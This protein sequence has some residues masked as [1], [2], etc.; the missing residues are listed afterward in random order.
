[1]GVV[2]PNHYLDKFKSDHTHKEFIVDPNPNIAKKFEKIEFA[3]EQVY[4]KGILSFKKSSSVFEFPFASDNRGFAVYNDWVD[5]N[6]KEN[7]TIHSVVNSSN[8]TFV[9]GEIVSYKK[10][11]SKMK[12]DI[13]HFFIRDDG[14]ILARSVNCN[15]VE[16][17]NC[18]VH[19]LPILKTEEYIMV[20]ETLKVS[21]S[22][23]GH[24]ML[25]MKLNESDLAFKKESVKTEDGSELKLGD[26]FYSVTDSFEIVTSNFVGELISGRSFLKQENAEKFA[27]DN[28]PMFSKKQISDASDYD[29]KSTYLLIDKDKLGF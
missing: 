8:E 12:W 6:L 26:P 18:L 11:E 1:M 27:D 23:I 3:K 19:P 25:R 24:T 10:I 21:A 20:G 5:F 22:E 14:M 28:K 2:I 16:D 29:M 4:P 9:V 13:N 15:H 17:V 7:H